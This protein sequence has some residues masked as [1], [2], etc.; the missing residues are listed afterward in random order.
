MGLRADEV[1]AQLVMQAKDRERANTRKARD[2]KTRKAKV[3]RDTPGARAMAKL[4]GML[5][6][7]KSIMDRNVVGKVAANAR[8]DPT[9]VRNARRALLANA[10]V[11][12]ER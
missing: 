9:T 11:K 5:L 7:G 12:R 10:E 2:A 1:K 4:E 8:C 3:D 6:Q